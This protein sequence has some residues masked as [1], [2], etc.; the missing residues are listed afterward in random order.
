MSKKDRVAIVVSFLYLLFPLAVLLDGA[1][2]APIAAIIFLSPLIM[3]WG[4][5]FIKNDISFIKNSGSE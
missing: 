2:D 4:Y 5:R 3:Y 1:S